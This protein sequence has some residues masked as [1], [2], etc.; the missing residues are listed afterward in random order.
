MFRKKWNFINVFYIP[1]KKML[2]ANKIPSNN[3]DYNINLMNENIHINE[4]INKYSNFL[5]SL[6][7]TFFSFLDL[8]NI[9]QLELIIN[10]S[11]TLEYQYFFKK[12]NL[13]EISPIFHILNFIK[14]KENIK[15]LNI[16]LNILDSII[17]K[18]IFYL[19]H[20]NNSLSE[21][22]ISFFSSDVLYL[23]N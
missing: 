14:N 17:S 19:I 5:N 21:L 7:I 12:Y 16:E 23:Q 1:E 8:I 9:N 3:S 15:S 4:L 10:D 18:K 11:Y 13:K 6:L 2:N 20:K 22:Q